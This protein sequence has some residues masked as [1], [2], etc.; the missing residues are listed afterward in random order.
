MFSVWTGPKANRQQQLILIFL[1]YVRVTLIPVTGRRPDYTIFSVDIGV[2]DVT[3]N[4][5]RFFAVTSTTCST[6]V[7][8]V[9][10]PPIDIQQALV[11]HTQ[12]VSVPIRRP[13][14]RSSVSHKL[15]DRHIV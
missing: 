8:A 14:D 11:Q 15:R 10:A 1:Q 7:T 6:L 13:S 9:F 5:R 4:S 2:T 12:S 3:E